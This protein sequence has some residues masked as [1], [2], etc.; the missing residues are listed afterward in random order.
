MRNDATARRRLGVSL[1][2]ALTAAALGCSAVSVRKVRPESTT[3][4]IQAA[5]FL[6]SPSPTTAAVLARAG[7]GAGLPFNAIQTV[8]LLERAET[9]APDEP[10]VRAARAE[11]AYRAGREAEVWARD[12]ATSLYLAAVAESYGLLA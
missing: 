9:P 11:V 1:L 6:Q 2:A 7:T 4:R 5:L 8:T 3:E 12:R 10:A